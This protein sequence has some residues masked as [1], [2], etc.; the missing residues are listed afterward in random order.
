MTTAG[1][2][3]KVL[4]KKF[5]IKCNREVLKGETYANQIIM[6]DGDEVVKVYEKVLH[7]CCGGAIRSLKLTKSD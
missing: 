3:E 6:I 7:R 2:T 5:C 1:I 4:E